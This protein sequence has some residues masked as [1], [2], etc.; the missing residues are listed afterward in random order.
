MEFDLAANDQ[1]PNDVVNGADNERAPQDEDNS[2]PQMAG[3]HE[4]EGSGQPDQ[5][6]SDDRDKR[7]NCSSDPEQQG[8]R[9]TEDGAGDSGEQALDEADGENAVQVG[10]DAVA[11]SAQQA[12]GL[13]GGEREHGSEVLDCGGSVTE[14]EEQ[15]QECKD[16]IPGKA[17]QSCR[18]AGA[19]C[20]EELAG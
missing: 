6:G 4:V 3:A 13:L 1:R 17:G 14:Y 5:H 15:D 9:H 10:D 12:H 16:C 7:T 20:Q 11:N 19:S 18:Q 2:F 8:R